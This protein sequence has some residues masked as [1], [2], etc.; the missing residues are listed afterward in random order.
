M[1]AK[2]AELLRSITIGEL[3]VGTFGDAC[4]T[5][6]KSCT[7]FEVLK[8]LQKH[9]VPAIP[10][11]DESGC[12]FDAYSRSDVRVSHSFREAIILTQLFVQFLAMDKTY[13]KLDMSVEQALSEHHVGQTLFFGNSS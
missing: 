12:Y 7:L 6:T 3:D 11:I 9:R 8:L 4:L 13:D 2:H 10:I 5:T 1:Q